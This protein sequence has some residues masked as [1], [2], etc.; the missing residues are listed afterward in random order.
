MQSLKL[1]CDSADMTTSN[2]NWAE[3][4]TGAATALLALA[5]FIALGQI[6]Q[7]RHARY[8]QAATDAARRWDDPA[9][10]KTRARVQSEVDKGGPDGLMADGESPILSP[11][12][13]SAWLLL[14][15]FS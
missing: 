9:F 11:P 15:G 14:F 4:L 6:R 10:R 5:A 8:A 1:L 7:A 2:P 3:V 12:G 13:S